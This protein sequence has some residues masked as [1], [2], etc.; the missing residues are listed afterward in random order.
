MVSSLLFPLFSL[1]SITKPTD[2]S[3]AST[4]KPR[5]PS[6][7][8]DLSNASN[9]FLWL[10]TATWSGVVVLGVGATSEVVSKT[11]GTA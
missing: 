9:V 7:D 3:L 5:E 10:S 6:S 8:W 1:T 4:T 2:P 11:G